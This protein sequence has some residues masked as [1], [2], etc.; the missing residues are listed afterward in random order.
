MHYLNDEVHDYQGNDDESEHG[1]GHHDYQGGA[2]HREKG[3]QERRQRLG[4][5]LVNRLDVLGKAV[6]DASEGRGLKKRHGG[7]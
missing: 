2:R 4:Y 7:A 3:V 6:E 5:S 1:R